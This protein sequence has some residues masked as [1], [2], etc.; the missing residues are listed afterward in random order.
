M[1]KIIVKIK[2]PD[3]EIAVELK[4]IVHTPLAKSL[5]KLFNHKTRV[6]LAK[7]LVRPITWLYTEIIEEL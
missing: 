4:E 1:A 2:K 3:K 7:L 6:R 5:G